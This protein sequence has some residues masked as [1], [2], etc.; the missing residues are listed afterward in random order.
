MQLLHPSKDK[1]NK[2]QISLPASQ[3]V[4]DVGNLLGRLRLAHG[5]AVPVRVPAAALVL[6]VLL[7][8]HPAALAKL[9]LR[10]GPQRLADLGLAVVQPGVP[11]GVGVGEQHLVLEVLGPLAD[12]RLGARRQHV[13]LGCDLGAVALERQ[14]VGVEAEGLFAFLVVISSV[15]IA[16]TMI[17]YRRLTFRV[18]CTADPR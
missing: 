16:R 1:L 4:L 11:A 13:E 14:V 7:A 9:E 12:A 8:H 18:Q 3:P 2:S 5:P 6:A 17:K 10:L 15:F